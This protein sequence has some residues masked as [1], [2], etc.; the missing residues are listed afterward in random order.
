V[1]R[2]PLSITK[3]VTYLLFSFTMAFYAIFSGN[4][5][6]PAQ[7]LGVWAVGILFWTLVEYL[8][9][10]FL[11]HPWGAVKKKKL[12]PPL[13]VTHGRHH[14]FPAE[15]AIGFLNPMLGIPLMLLMG[16]LFYLPMS[17]Y[18][19]LF[20]SGF[21]MGYIAYMLI[22]LAIHRSNPASSWIASLRRHH[23]LHHHQYPDKC[24]G[25]T[26]IFWDR[27]FGTFESAGGTNQEN[28]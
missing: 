2:K 15:M 13:L 14:R 12:L 20:L 16:F 17:G 21:I 26:T 19:F 24:F 10:R 6:G 5:G 22:H 25:V 28:E 23:F 27:L 9:H 7:G 8:I 3:L 1:E 18:A 4:A 11:F